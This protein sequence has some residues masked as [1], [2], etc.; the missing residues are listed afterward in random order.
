MKFSVGWDENATHDI[1]LGWNAAHPELR[2]GIAAALEVIEQL[3]RDHPL[4]VGES[5]GEEVVRV[6]IKPPLTVHFRVI[7]S[8]R[9]VR[10]FAA[11][12]FR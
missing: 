6:V 4:E 5:R 10:V 11:R 2:E 3:L 7:A 9:F 8:S 12:V 1:D